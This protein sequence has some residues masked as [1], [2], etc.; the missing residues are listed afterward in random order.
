MG[1]TNSVSNTVTF[2]SESD[3]SEHK[4]I[5]DRI[6][7]L[8][9]GLAWTGWDSAQVEV[10]WSPDVVPGMK[11]PRCVV[12]PSNEPEDYADRTNVEFAAIYPARIYLLDRIRGRAGSMEDLL[13][14]REQIC[15]LFKGITSLQ[16]I[17][18]VYLVEVVPFAIV[19]DEETVRNYY[20]AG[21]SVRVHVNDVRG[22]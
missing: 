6:E 9:E 3:A 13:H 5:L 14:K 22:A 19:L 2:W 11:Y 17:T 7:A 1:D 10:A 21:V 4:A 18:G 20:A 15:K 16:E 12:C 8:I